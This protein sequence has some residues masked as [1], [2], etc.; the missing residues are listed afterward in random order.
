MAPYHP[1]L[2]DMYVYI[3]ICCIVYPD[4]PSNDK[5]IGTGTGTKH[6]GQYTNFVGTWRVY[7]Y[8]GI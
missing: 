4:S 8:N 1:L 7:V 2:G 3:Y 6:M 5:K